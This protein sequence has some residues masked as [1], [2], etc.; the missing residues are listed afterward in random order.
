MTVK[1]IK[2]C[3]YHTCRNIFSHCYQDKESSTIIKSN[4]YRKIKLNLTHYLNHSF[5]VIQTSLPLGNH[6]LQC[7]SSSTSQPR[8]HSTFAR[9]GNTPGTVGPLHEWLHRSSNVTAKKAKPVW[10]PSTTLNMTWR[11]FA[12]NL[13]RWNSCKGT[14][15]DRK[16]KKKK[17]QCNWFFEMRL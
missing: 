3:L 13:E 6:S 10:A 16:K 12:A 8:L 1:T 15:Y 14:K 7:F 17:N 2:K 9:D 4:L 11:L 5:L